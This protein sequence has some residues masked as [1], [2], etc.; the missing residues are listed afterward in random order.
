[1]V[2]FSEPDSVLITGKGGGVGNF[3]EF[4]THQVQ[5]RPRRNRDRAVVVGTVGFNDDLFLVGPP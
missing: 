5:I 1:M 4:R 3:F 2:L